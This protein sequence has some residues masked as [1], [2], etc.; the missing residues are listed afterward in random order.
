MKKE[1]KDRNWKQNG[2]LSI[3]FCDY[4][5][6]P[7]CDPSGGSPAYRRKIEK[8][9]D[10]GLCPACGQ[11]PCKCKST[12]LSKEAFADREMWIAKRKCKNCKHNNNCNVKDPRTC[13]NFERRQEE[14]DDLCEYV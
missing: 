3:D 8:R 10:N 13:K 9:L 6:K 7:G 11:M 4:C 1:R 14:I 12:G 5:F 2:K